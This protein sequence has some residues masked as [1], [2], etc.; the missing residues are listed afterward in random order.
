MIISKKYSAGFWVLLGAFMFSIMNALAKLIPFVDGPEISPLQTTFSRYA[1][2]MI[3]TLPF[4]IFKRSRL[5]TRYSGRYLVRTAAGLGGIALM[6]L[7]VTLIPLASATAIGFTS[8]IFAIIFAWFLLG[9]AVG[10]SRWVGA[11]IGLCGAAIIAAPSG[12]SINPGAAIAMLAAVFM[13]AE[14]VGVKWLSRTED[15]AST[16]IFFSNLFGTILALG[17]TLPVLVIPNYEQLLII[18]SLGVSAVL[19]QIC[20]LRASRMSDASFLAPFFYVSLLYS[21]IIG[22]FFF[23]EHISLSIVLGCSAILAGAAIN[24][25]SVKDSPVYKHE[26]KT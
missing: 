13:G 15:H 7:A 20:I 2:A 8:P 17:L 26:V 25:A 24:M 23:G 1:I 19:G 14:V 4:V 11:V 5:K 18:V 16:I 21:A 22:F 12:Y 9:E 6:F 10:V 3:A